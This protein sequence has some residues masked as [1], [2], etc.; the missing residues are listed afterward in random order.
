[1]VRIFLEVIRSRVCFEGGPKVSEDGPRV[2][3]EGGLKVSEGGPKAD[4]ERRPGV[5]SDVKVVRQSVL[6]VVRK[7]MERCADALVCSV[8]HCFLTIVSA[9]RPRFQNG[10]YDF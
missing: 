5:R 7:A 1:V 3:S 9:S 10:Y 6:K 4:S 2:R 8:W